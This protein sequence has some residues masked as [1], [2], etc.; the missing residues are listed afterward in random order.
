MAEL[1][2]RNPLRAYRNYCVAVKIYVAKK[3]T[4]NSYNHVVVA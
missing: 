3:I 1:Q 2:K 4:A